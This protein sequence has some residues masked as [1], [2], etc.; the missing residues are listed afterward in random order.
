MAQASYLAISPY[1]KKDGQ[2]G[3]SGPSARFYEYGPGEYL[4]E[5]GGNYLNPYTHFD[6]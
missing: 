3:P 6:V 2:S 5:Q 4:V 1:L